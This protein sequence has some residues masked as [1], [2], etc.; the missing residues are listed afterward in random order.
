MTDFRDFAHSLAAG[1]ALPWVS[2][3]DGDGLATVSSPR[4]SRLW[5]WIVLSLVALETILMALI[6]G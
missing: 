3:E 1:P 2:S 6:Q 5:P 4:W